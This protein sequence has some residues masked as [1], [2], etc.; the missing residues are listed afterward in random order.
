MATSKD[1][2]DT[3]STNPQSYVWPNTRIGWFAIGFSV[4]AMA[5]WFILPLITITFGKTYP[6]TDSWV[7]PAI[8]TVLIDLAAII[9]VFVLWRLKERSAMNIVAT[10]LVG[11]TA[12]FFTFM[13]IGEALGGS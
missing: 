12:L 6:I 3:T 11:P 1:E 2:L 7:M 10:V 5:S 4:I 8:G 13:V 9:N